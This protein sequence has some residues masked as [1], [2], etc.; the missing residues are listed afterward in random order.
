MRLDGAKK[1]GGLRMVRKKTWI[2]LLGKEQ[3]CC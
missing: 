1:A 2:K 3:F